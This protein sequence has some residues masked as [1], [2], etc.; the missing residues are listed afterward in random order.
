MAAGMEKRKV[1][2]TDLVF[3]LAIATKHARMMVLLVTMAL[4]AGLVYYVYARPVYRSISVVKYIDTKPF[5]D[6]EDVDGG[7]YYKSQI[8]QE[9]SAPHIL[10]RAEKRLGFTRRV[11]DPVKP[12][13]KRVSASF[14]SEG[15]IEV[16]TYVFEKSWAKP[17]PEIL[18]E[19]LMAERAERSKEIRDR[20]RKRYSADMERI[21]QKIAETL[22]EKQKLQDIYNPDQLQIELD[23]LKRIPRELFQVRQKIDQ[24]ERIKSKLHSAQSLSIIERLTLYTGV[25]LGLKLG[26]IVP[27]E[28]LP[29]SAPETGSSRR[30]PGRILNF[31]GPGL[32]GGDQVQSRSRI[33]SHNMLESN[34]RTWQELERERYRLEQ[35]MDKARL[36][37]LDRHPKMLEL[38]QQIN[39]VKKQLETALYNAAYAFD[40]SYAKLKDQERQLLIKLPE[41]E[42]KQ[43]QM[44]DYLRIK[45]SQEM[46]NRW[47]NLWKELMQKIEDVELVT[48][49]E[50]RIQLQFL[51]WKLVRDRIP[52]SPPRF[53]L[54][55]FA[56]LMG[57]A[58]AV[59][60]PFLLEFLDQTVTNMDKLEAETHMK[61]LGLVPDFEDTI[62]EAY[63]LIG[64]ESMTDPDMLENFRVIRTNLAAA[65]ATSKYPQVIMVTS[66]GPKE[67]KTVVSS[68]LA[69]S[70][71]QMGD[72]TLF[73]D[74]NLRR[75]LVH[76]LFSVRSSPGLSNTLVEKL[77]VSEAIRETAVE[78]LSVLPT[79]DHLDGDIEML[80]S[81]R[82]QQVMD[83]LRGKYQRIVMDAPPILG[84]S[85]TAVM[86][87]VIDGVVMV[88]WSAFTSTRQIRTAMDILGDNHANF[89]GFVLNRL[90]L[91]ATMNRFHYYYYSNHYYNRYQSM[92]H[93]S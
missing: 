24:F 30:R 57:I 3:Y 54:V 19:E 31:G 47:E 45:G 16:D 42:Q 2:F 84:L 85:E 74:T 18:V 64:S 23:E 9:L 65:A 29:G 72:K 63:P 40:L 67:G 27:A 20:Y 77:E 71:A 33:V 26:E 32:Q 15:N 53:K 39:A 56:F 58:L 38:K 1:D 59:G 75:G 5:Q 44:E 80:G 13:L 79:G 17:F 36:K 43:K 6:V 61:G 55:L 68:N 10:A 91:T 4:V 11:R 37:Y 86:Q 48:E 60:I 28:P 8:L 46:G 88:I 82:M 81:T 25:D 73:I 62:A 89:Y 22:A 50:D 21:E 78:N 12:L 34:P 90:D 70:F 76:H 49:G 93:V 35:E 7:R 92:T 51:T 69:L 66:T 52:V 83:E 87:P 41:Y 14:N